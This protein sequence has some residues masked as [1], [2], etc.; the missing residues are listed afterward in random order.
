VDASSWSVT[1]TAGGSNAVMRLLGTLSY[2]ICVC[3][4][5]H[6]YWGNSLNLHHAK[7]SSVVSCTCM[8]PSDRSLLFRLIP[9]HRQIGAGS[10]SRLPSYTYKRLTQCNCQLDKLQVNY[11]FS[12]AHFG[13]LRVVRESSSR[14]VCGTSQERLQRTI[15]P[16]N[17]MP[18][19][20]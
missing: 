9:Q 6:L 3:V 17:Q 2:Y 7:Y 20:P 14:N 13:S 12:L 5:R 18:T 16:R 8:R 10:P 19:R 15:P 1:L 11:C 4:V